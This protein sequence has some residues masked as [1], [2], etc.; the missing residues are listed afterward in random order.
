[1]VLWVLRR[2]VLVCVHGC[3]TRVVLVWD[4][5]VVVR[6]APRSLEYLH[7]RVVVVVLLLLLLFRVPV[8]VKGLLVF[9]GPV[10]R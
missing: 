1:M 6:Y 9:G 5:V 10:G 4:E 2:G 7:A 8:G 3:H